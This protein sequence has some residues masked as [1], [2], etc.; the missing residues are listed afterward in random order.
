M[1][2]SAK[3]K[4]KA[5]RTVGN[6]V[7]AACSRVASAAPC[8]N[9]APM[10]SESVVAMPGVFELIRPA[11]RARSVSSAVLTRFPLCPRATPVPAAVVRKTG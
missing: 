9:N 1:F 7:M 10:M 8:A 5:P 3:T 11:S 2:S 4:Q 6:S